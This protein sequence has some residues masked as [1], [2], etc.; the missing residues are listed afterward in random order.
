M[1]P[2]ASI[3]RNRR[4]D[5]GAS[6]ALILLLVG[7]CAL[8]GCAKVEPRANVRE[9]PPACVALGPEAFAAERRP[10]VGDREITDQEAARIIS[11]AARTIRAYE[12][13]MRD[14]GDLEAARVA[15]RC[16]EGLPTE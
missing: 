13:R 15:N 16:L 6:I 10:S 12:S 5:G 9:L 4:G 1:R 8:A 7:G 14:L 11:Q 2:L 3:R